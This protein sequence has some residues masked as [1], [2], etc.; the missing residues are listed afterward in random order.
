[1]LFRSVVA[2]GGEGAAAEHVAQRVDAPGDVLQHRDAH[3][4][5]PQQGGQGGAPGAANQPPG[6]ER[7]GEG[8]RAEGGNAAETARMA[9]SASMSGAY[10]A[11]GVGSSRSTIHAM[12]PITD[13]LSQ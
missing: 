9:G 10:R 3:Q 1:M 7:Q 8:Q 6:A 13:S 4:P 5:R 2:P 12:M 11:G